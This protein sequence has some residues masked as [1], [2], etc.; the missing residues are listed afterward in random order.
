M[1]W[2]FVFGG[3][4]VAGLITLVAYAVW[5]AHKASD[6]FAE[7]K[8]LGKRSEQLLEIVSRIQLPDSSAIEPGPAARRIRPAADQTEQNATSASLGTTVDDVG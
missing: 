8:V 6:V 7:V 1:I 4:A 5:L 3:I 2:V